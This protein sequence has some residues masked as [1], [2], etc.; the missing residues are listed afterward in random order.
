MHQLTKGK[1]FANINNG[2]LMPGYT[3]MRHP[4]THTG[5]G[6]NF[7]TVTEPSLYYQPLHPFQPGL[8]TN[9]PQI[10]QSFRPFIMQKV[11]F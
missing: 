5:H 6:Y 1:T 7:K 10:K 4:S 11:R 2:F 3:R 9:S 8:I